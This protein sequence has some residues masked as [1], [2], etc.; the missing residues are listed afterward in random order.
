MTRLLLPTRRNVLAGGGAMAAGAALGLPA[1]A[2]SD[3]PD[4]TIA[5]QALVDNFEP[6]QAI[7]NVGMRVVNAMFDTLFYRNY[8]GNPDGSGNQIQPAIATGIERLDPQRVRVTIRDDVRFH[9]GA[10]VTSQDVAFSFGEDRMFGP[11]PLTPR[12]GYFRPDLVEV[13]ALDDRTVEFV[14][15][16]P[17]YA[18]EKRL[19]SWIGWVV[20]EGPFRDMGLDGFGQAPIGTGPYK[21]KEFIRGDRIVLEANDDYYR[22]RPTARTITFIVVPETATRVAG[23][24]SGEYD[25]ACA[26]SP[27]DLDLLARYDDVDARGAQIENTHLIVH[28]QVDNILSDKRIRKAMALCVDRDTLNTALWKGKA[29]VTNGFQMPSQGVAFDP[30]RP[31]YSQQIGTAKQLL[32]EAG[33]A[34]ETITF[35]TLN[36]YY[37]NSVAAAQVMQ[38]W[39]QEAGLNVELVI[40]ENWGQVTGD[41][42][43]TRNW[44]NGFPLPDPVAPLT[45]DWGPTSNVQANYGWKAPEEFN[46]LLD[47]IKTSP[48]GPDRTAAFQRALD[49]FDDEA[50]GFPLYRPYEL[51]GVRANINWRPVTFEWMDLRP[52]NLTFG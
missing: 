47:T 27:D 52:N 24:I 32:S 31:A 30:N 22:G 3:R 15:A 8:L 35:R 21:M 11:E 19:A 29:G 42:L 18:M 39:W 45:T 1:L 23:L 5:V 34:G 25:F 2:Q 20:P 33:Y 13:T 17:D 28:N 14:T 49:I 36:D 37:V 16:A 9:D 46:S 7:S 6:I 44:S 50:P 41:G 40:M 43:M 26:L 4:V 12:A 48:D 51:Y 38:Q 10:P